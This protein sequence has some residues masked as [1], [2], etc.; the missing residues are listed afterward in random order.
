M[1]GLQQN[2][3]LLVKFLQ[4]LGRHTRLGVLNGHIFCL[5]PNCFVNLKQRHTTN[6]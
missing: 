4:Y 3:D 6:V 1:V 5:P 2:L